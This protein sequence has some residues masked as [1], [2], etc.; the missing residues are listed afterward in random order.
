MTSAE[1]V[2]HIQ[3]PQRLQQ[4]NA[5]GGS[6]EAQE[7]GEDSRYGFGYHVGTG[8]PRGTDR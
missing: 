8:V 7:Y 1:A 2:Q 6:I 4:K 3:A 5:S